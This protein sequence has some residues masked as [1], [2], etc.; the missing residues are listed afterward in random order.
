MTIDISGLSYAECE[1]LTHQ[2]ELRIQQLRDQAKADLVDQAKRMHLDL[3]D[4][5]DSTRPKRR[6]RAQA[7]SET[8][9]LGITVGSTTV[10]GEA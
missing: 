7:R 4:L 5:A 1:E 8:N 3:S 10:D 6:A 9:G 2:L